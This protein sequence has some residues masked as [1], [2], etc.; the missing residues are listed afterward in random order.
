MPQPVAAVA[1]KRASA[2]AHGLSSQSPGASNALRFRRTL[3]S[4]DGGRG[5]SVPVSAL[6]PTLP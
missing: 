4:R 5:Y 2:G 6:F 3:S 1:G